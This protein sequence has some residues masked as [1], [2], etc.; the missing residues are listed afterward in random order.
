[1]NKDTR[2]GLASP[3][4]LQIPDC[5]TLLYVPNILRG[6]SS[7]KQALPSKNAAKQRITGGG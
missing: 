3:N 1:M 6:W 4:I 7:S 5:H 2:P